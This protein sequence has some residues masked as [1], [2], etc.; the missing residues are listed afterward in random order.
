MVALGSF[1]RNARVGF[2]RVTETVRVVVRVHVEGE[3]VDLVEGLVTDGAF[4]LLLPAVRQ[5]VVLVV[6]CRADPRSV[7]RPEN[8]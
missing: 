5:L 3:V 6:P 2:L 7:D 1:T 4:V 8:S